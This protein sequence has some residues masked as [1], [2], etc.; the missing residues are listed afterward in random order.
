MVDKEYWQQHAAS[1]RKFLKKN[2][3]RI[4]GR[5]IIEKH[6]ASIGVTEKSALDSYRSIRLMSGK[7][8]LHYCSLQGL[9]IEF[10]AELENNCLFCEAVIY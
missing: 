7:A 6:G 2:Y 10:R 5:V 9:D 1:L 3:P 8:L 4:V